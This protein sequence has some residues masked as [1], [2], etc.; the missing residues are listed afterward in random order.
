MKSTNY[1]KRTLGLRGF[2]WLE[3]FLVSAGPR[4]RDLRL[5]DRY[6]LFGLFGD[7]TGS[8]RD[9]REIRV[10]GV[11]TVRGDRTQSLS[12]QLWKISEQLQRLRIR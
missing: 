2:G 12:R 3:S 11:P 4:G 7:A 6:G 9:I 1:T 10:H 5:C 8:I